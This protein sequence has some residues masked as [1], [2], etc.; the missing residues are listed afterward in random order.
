MSGWEKRGIC[1]VQLMDQNNPEVLEYLKRLTEAS[2][3]SL[4]K[5]DE[6]LKYTKRALTGSFVV[7]GFVVLL[8]I[9]GTVYDALKDDDRTETSDWYGA[10]YYFDYRDFEP[11]LRYLDILI[12]KNPND[13]YAHYRKGEVL[14]LKGDTAGAEQS[15]L[16][17][18][19]IFP[20]PKHEEAV[21]AIGLRIAAPRSASS[22]SD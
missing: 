18:R 19:D 20:I 22:Q 6:M 5:S 4:R 11:T 3:Q 16:K 14:L 21:K 17:A 15:F 7:L 13:Y 1:R 12:G 9:A 2:E 10:D 8:A